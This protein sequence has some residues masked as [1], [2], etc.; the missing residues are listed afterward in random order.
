MKKT[1]GDLYN[2]AFFLNVDQVST[3][4]KHWHFSIHLNCKLCSHPLPPSVLTITPHLVHQSSLDLS[5]DGTTTK[6]QMHSAASLHRQFVCSYFDDTWHKLLKKTKNNFI[7]KSYETGDS[8]FPTRTDVVLQQIL[9]VGGS[10][11]SLVP[12][13]T[14]L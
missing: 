9:K 2:T 13:C 4:D 12:H 1:S 14:S 7:D 11:E 8:V 5:P 3:E 6:M 10:H